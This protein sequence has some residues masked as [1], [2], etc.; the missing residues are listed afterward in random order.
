M[1]EQALKPQKATGISVE[2]F[3]DAQEA[4]SKEPSVGKRTNLMRY[5]VLILA[6]VEPM[7]SFGEFEQMLDDDID[8]L[9]QECKKLNPRHFAQ[10]Q[11]EPDEKKKES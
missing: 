8:N 10:S 11:E 9:V 7:P 6:R 5:S 1:S 2:A 4:A 3:Y